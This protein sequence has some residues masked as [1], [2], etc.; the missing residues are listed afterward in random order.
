MLMAG[1]E[2][3][4]MFILREQNFELMVLVFFII[5]NSLRKGRKS[6][7]KIFT[8]FTTLFIGQSVS[9]VGAATSGYMILQR[10]SLLK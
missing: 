1:Y 3:K 8:I 2:R 9:T 5:F 7:A 6:Q 10:S 4:E